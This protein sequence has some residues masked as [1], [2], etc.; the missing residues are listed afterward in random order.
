MKLKLLKFKSN[1]FEFYY[2]LV[3][4]VDVMKQ[5]TERALTYDEASIKYQ[6]IINCNEQFDGFGS[7]KIYDMENDKFVGLGHLTL[8]EEKNSEAEIGYMFLPEFWGKGYGS[9]IAKQLVEIAM[10]LNITTIKAI[11]DPNNIP[12]RRI[13]INLG[14]VSQEFR[15]I[16]GLSGEILSK[17][18]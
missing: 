1:D 11:I 7:Y 6:N 15:L 14:F 12:S 13:L 10:E 5:I 16:K 4:N 18:I 3:S 17:D 2:S 8:N 9:K